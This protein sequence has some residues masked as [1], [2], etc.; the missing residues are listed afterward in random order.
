MPSKIKLYMFCVCEIFFVKLKF[1]NWY[2]YVLG[3]VLLTKKTEKFFEFRADF[4][5]YKNT[6]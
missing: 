5:I 3:S 1:F 2:N 4:Q 6:L